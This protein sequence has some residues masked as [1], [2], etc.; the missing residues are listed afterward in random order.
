M[1]PTSHL[2][3]P[4]QL[5]NCVPVQRHGVGYHQRTRIQKAQRKKE[6]RKKAVVRGNIGR[7][8]PPTSHPRRVGVT[9]CDRGWNA[10]HGLQHT[11]SRCK[12]KAGTGFDTRSWRIAIPPCRLS[13]AIDATP[14]NDQLPRAPIGAV[15]APPSTSKHTVRCP[16]WPTAPS[17]VQG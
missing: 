17:P 13:H 9:R 15:A 3:A 12:W 6:E 16:H 4:P 7:H 8:I 2:S 5:P 10:A 11:R 1:D 14:P